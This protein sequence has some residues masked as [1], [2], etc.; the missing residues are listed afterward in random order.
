MNS[1][2]KISCRPADDKFVVLFLRMR[3]INKNELNLR[4]SKGSTL[5]ITNYQITSTL[6]N[7]F[8]DFKES[9]LNLSDYFNVNIILAFSKRK[10]NE[11]TLRKTNFCTSREVS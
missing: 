3:D 8:K 9:Q 10:S 6:L 7:L 5:K 2:T 11:F 4:P 1:L